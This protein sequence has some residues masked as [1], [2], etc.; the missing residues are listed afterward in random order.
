MK[1]LLLILVL[2]LLVS[3]LLFGWDKVASAQQATH[4]QVAFNLL[5]MRFGGSGYVAS[6]ALSELI[7]KHSPWLRAKFSETAG[8]IAN[9]RAFSENPEK[10]KDSL[11]Y[12]TW[13]ATFL[14]VNAVPPFFTKPYKGARAI[15]MAQWIV[16]SYVT[17]DPKIK[18]PMDFVGKR[19]GLPPKASSGRVE[20]EILLKYGWGIMDKVKIDY[21]GFSESIQ[22]LRDGM[23]DV[24]IYNPIYIGVDKVA[25]SPALEELKAL[26]VPYYYIPIPKEDVIR[27]RK[28][29]GYP[30]FPAVLPPGA[31]GPEQTEPFP[32]VK[33]TNGWF[34]DVEF[35]DD[36][37]YEICRIIY[38]HYK[39]FWAYHV[40]LRG[41]SP[42][43]MPKLA[44]SE[45]EYHPGAI[46]FYKEKGLK[47]G[48]SD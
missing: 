26:R 16:H 39:E 24:A 7:N 31:L 42:E 41:L 23:V 17:L 6:F 36:M 32:H 45:A 28:K 19:I 21:I 33:L 5:S 15:S 10:R 47:I 48:F 4:K 3:G 13:S 2:S 25:P 40:S 44:A 14:A 9:M 12:T 37:A 20:P 11:A 18:T 1:K 34:A 8:G 43:N 46:K 27:A 29:S 38:E 35:G 22:A 30:I